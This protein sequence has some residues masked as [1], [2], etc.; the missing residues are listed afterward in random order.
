MARTNG[1]EP[2]VSTQQLGEMLEYSD[3]IWSIVNIHSR[4]T[5]RLNVPLTISTQGTSGAKATSKSCLK[6]AAKY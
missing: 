1:S 5:D 6:V 3:P 4:N 2:G